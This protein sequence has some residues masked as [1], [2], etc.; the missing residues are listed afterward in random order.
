MVALYGESFDRER[1]ENKHKLIRK[2]YSELKKMIRSTGFGRDPLRGM[3]YPWAGKFRGKS[4]HDV[5][6]L[7]KIFGDIVIDGRHCETLVDRGTDDNAPPYE[8]NDSLIESPHLDT[9]DEDNDISTPS[10]A[11]RTSSRQYKRPRP[12][13]PSEVS[14]KK[15]QST[16]TEQV[17]QV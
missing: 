7:D 4:A 16:L 5:N 15:R 3:D 9:S 1:M 12:Y 6:E 2:M 10:N 14:Q 13:T 8:L 11:R 17:A